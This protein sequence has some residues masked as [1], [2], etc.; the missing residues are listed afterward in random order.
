MVTHYFLQSTLNVCPPPPQA[1]PNTFPYTKITIIVVSVGAS[2]S[3]LIFIVAM[4]AAIISL[5]HKPGYTRIG[6][7]DG[8]AVCM[9]PMGVNDMHAIHVGSKIMHVYV[10]RYLLV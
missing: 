2:L 6:G 10:Q 4:I 8:R 5:L 9:A 3:V 1:S 7:S